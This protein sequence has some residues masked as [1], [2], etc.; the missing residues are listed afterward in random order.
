MIRDEGKGQFRDNFFKQNSIQFYIS[1]NC[2]NLEKQLKEQNNVDG[3][4]EKA[5]KCLI[6]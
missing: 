6:F 1:K 2:L 5:D 3:R 4:Y